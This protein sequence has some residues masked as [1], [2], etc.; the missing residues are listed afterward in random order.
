MGEKNMATATQL[1][2]LGISSNWEKPL[3]DACEKFGIDT[4]VRQAAFIGQCQHESGN[5]KHLIENLNFSAEGL[6]RTFPHQFPTMEAAGSYSRNPQRIANKVYANR[7]GNGPEDSGDGWAF[8]GRGLIQ[9]TGKSNYIQC[10]EALGMDL[11]ATPAFLESPEGAC[12]SAAWF[13]SIKNLNVLADAQNWEAMTKRINGGT[14]GLD[15]RISRIQKALEA[16]S[17]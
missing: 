6:C 7:L 9:L 12:L 2:E 17:V 10:G 8:R 15:D 4:P 13:W 14:I 1:S 11:I 3:N 16:L 5:F